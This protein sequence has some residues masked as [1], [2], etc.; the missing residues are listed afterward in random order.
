M[1][2]EIRPTQTPTKM[3][4]ILAF[5]TLLTLA[6][7]VSFAQKGYRIEV[8]ID[9]LSNTQLLLGYHLGDKKFVADTAQVDS[10]GIAVFKGDSLLKGGMYIVILP[11]HS[12]FDILVDKNQHFKIRTQADRLLDELSFVGSPDNSAFVAY[13]RFM[14]DK[15]KEMAE[16]RTE[17]QKADPKSAR[18]KEL[19]ERINQLDT[20]VKANWDDIVKKYPG[21][22]LAAIIKAIKPI[23]IP[24]FSIPDGATNPDS[25][26]WVK[27]YAYNQLHYLD[28]IDLADDR[29][30]RT[31]FVQSKIDFYLEKVLLPIPD[32]VMLYAEKLIAR[33]E[34]NNQMFQFVLSQLLTKYQAS[35]IM[36]MDAVFVHIAEKY[37]L[38]G[39][40]TWLSD[41]IIGKIRNRVNEIKP[42]LIGSIAPNII[43][44]TWSNATVN[45]HSVKAKV[46]IVYFWEP[47]CSHCKKVTPLLK[48]KYDQYKP[49]GLEVFAVYT[50]G[51]QAAWKEY[52]EKNKLNWI[53][54]WDPYRYSN[55]HK[56]YDIYSTPIIYVLDSNKKIVAKRI[57]PE[58]LDSIFE[59]LLK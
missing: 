39:K 10:K 33:S 27:S 47:G 56:L 16:I 59:P 46:T 13:Q 11:Q 41:E 8:Q 18:E 14:N 52:A 48:E 23:E 53:N 24:E 4:K 31:P 54:V 19:N 20:Q 42:N 57:G 26:K 28:N 34:P 45:L 3:K 7:T 38:S 36:G 9:G 32:T 50:Q 1:I 55:Y 35:N 58:A 5:A 29:L 40:V 51:D 12:Y 43:A 22:L 2:F 15:Q 30:M 6:F 44:N 17:L 25:L 49:K 37:Y 21:T